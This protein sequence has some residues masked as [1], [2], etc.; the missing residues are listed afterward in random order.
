MNETKSIIKLFALITENSYLKSVFIGKAFSR[1]KSADAQDYYSN[2]YS[3]E[4]RGIHPHYRTN[5]LDEAFSF[6]SFNDCVIKE[7]F[8]GATEDTDRTVEEALQ[9]CFEKIDEQNK[10][11][12]E[13]LRNF[14]F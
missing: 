8:I 7:A 10:V 4:G 3:V 14:Y 5:V 6:I 12:S 9:E 13:S 11:V 2:A 1:Q